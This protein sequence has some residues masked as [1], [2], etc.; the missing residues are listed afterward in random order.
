M[1]VST[2]SCAVRCISIQKERM[3]IGLVI[4]SKRPMFLA[5][6]NNKRFFETVAPALEALL[7]IL[8]NQK[9]RAFKL[10]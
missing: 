8:E 2:K 10:N 3:D 5:P 1:L 7:S 9:R 6:Q 4:S